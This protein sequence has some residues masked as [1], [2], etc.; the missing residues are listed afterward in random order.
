MVSSWWNCQHLSKEAVIYYH[1]YTSIRV[2]MPDW[3]SKD[4]NQQK[5]TSIAFCGSSKN[6]APRLSCSLLVFLLKIRPWTFAVFACSSRSRDNQQEH[7]TGHFKL[8]V[9][10]RWGTEPTFTLSQKQVENWSSSFNAISLALGAVSFK[11]GYVLGGGQVPVPMFARVSQSASECAG[12]CRVGPQSACSRTWNRSS[13]NL[14]QTNSWI[15]ANS[16]NLKNIQLTC[17]FQC[18]SPA[19]RL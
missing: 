4:H 3:S 13:S 7:A 5:A 17:K 18:H 6:V 11:R 15:W 9:A 19:S 10:S 16:W 14:M 8:S 12:G 1:M 2:A